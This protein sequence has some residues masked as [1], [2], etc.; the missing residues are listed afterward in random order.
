MIKFTLEGLLRYVQS[1]SEPIF[2]CDPKNAS[3]N[4]QIMKKEQETIYII[5]ILFCEVEV[6]DIRFFTSGSFRDEG[7]TLENAIAQSYLSVIAATK[8]ALEKLQYSLSVVPSEEEF[9]NFFNESE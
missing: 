3:I 7:N 4:L 2:R 6:D 9:N 1:V 5:K 8:R